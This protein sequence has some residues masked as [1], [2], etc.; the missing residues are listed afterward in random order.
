MAMSTH[1]EYPAF[2]QFGTPYLIEFERVCGYQA[3]ER[4]VGRVSFGA[5]YQKKRKIDTLRNNHIYPSCL[6]SFHIPKKNIN[7]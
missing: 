1:M 7:S 5:P 4:W 6:I 2:Y 3:A